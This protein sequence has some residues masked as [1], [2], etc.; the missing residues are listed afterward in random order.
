MPSTP[1]FSAARRPTRFAA[2]WLALC[3]AGSLAVAVPDRSPPRVVAIG[4]VHGDADALVALL[5]RTGLV[6]E[7]RHWTGGTATLVQTGDVLD[8]GPQVRAVVDLL[9]ARSKARPRQ[10][11]ERSRSW[12]TTR[13]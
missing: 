10:R 11:V 5:Q 7:A 8:R 4:D 1:S 6:N 3:A 2:L 9:M 13:R 12:A